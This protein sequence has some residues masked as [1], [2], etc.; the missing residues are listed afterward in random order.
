MRLISED[1][2]ERVCCGPEWKAKLD[3][4]YPGSEEFYASSDYRQSSSKGRDFLST[5]SL[6][7]KQT[8]VK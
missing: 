2:F 6:R 8:V 3:R 5:L 1:L 7:K 4:S